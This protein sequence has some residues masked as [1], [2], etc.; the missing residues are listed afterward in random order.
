MLT[1]RIRCTLLILYN[2]TKNKGQKKYVNDNSKHASGMMIISYK[3]GFLKSCRETNWSITEKRLNFIFV[4][5]YK[6]QIYKPNIII[7]KRQSLI[8]VKHSTFLK[9]EIIQTGKSRNT[10]IYKEI[11]Y[12]TA[13]G[14]SF[15]QNMECFLIIC[16][17]NIK[18][19][20][21]KSYH[22][23]SQTTI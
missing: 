10:S 16:L 22:I 19:K 6:T 4:C 15:H 9:V 20:K 12:R 17:K 14:H 7:S 18:I 8:K 11:I 5:I 1:L 21:K 13:R 23:H 3:A 2:K